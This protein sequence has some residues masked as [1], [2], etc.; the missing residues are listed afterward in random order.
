MGNSMFCSACDPICFEPMD[1]VT[2]RHILADAEKQ[3]LCH[4]YEA[5]LASKEGEDGD[6]GKEGEMI[7]DKLHLLDHMDQNVYHWHVKGAERVNTNVSKLNVAIS[8][9]SAFIDSD[10]RLNGS[11]NMDEEITGNLKINEP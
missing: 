3:K 7:N 9:M 5:F 10:Q 6:E 11:F 4:E 1:L 2:P 8:P